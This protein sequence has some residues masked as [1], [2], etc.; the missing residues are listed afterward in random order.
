[1]SLAWFSSLLHTQLP[2]G[3]WSSAMTRPSPNSK[4]MD[5]PASRTQ[6]Q[7]AFYGIQVTQC[8]LEQQNPVWARHMPIIPALRRLSQDWELGASLGFLMRPCWER[9]QQGD[10]EGRK[11][12]EG[13]GAERE[14]EGERRGKRRKRR[15]KMEERKRTQTKTIIPV[16]L[17]QNW[18]LDGLLIFLQIHTENGVRTLR[19]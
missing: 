12:R 17:L 6:R 19:I 2:F 14:R 3:L 15:K 8:P 11:E 18:D 4:A 10:T 5:T 7:I 13:E 1:M 16:L 9:K